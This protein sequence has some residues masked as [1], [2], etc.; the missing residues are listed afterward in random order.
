MNVCIS[1]LMKKTISPTTYKNNMTSASAGR[2]RCRQSSPPL[3][4]ALRNEAVV[5]IPPSGRY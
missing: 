4:L 2:N 1:S 3:W 5:V